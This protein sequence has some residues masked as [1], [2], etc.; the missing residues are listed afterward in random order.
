MNGPVGPDDLI[1]LLLGVKSLFPGNIGVVVDGHRVGSQVEAYVVA[2]VLPAQNA[3][4]DMLA[5]VRCMWSK[6][7]AQSRTPRT[8]DP[9]FRGA[10]MVW[11]ITP[12]FS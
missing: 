2:V 3:A 10:S 12:S 8:G 9:T 11:K 7:R 6:R 1:G 5:G 4:E